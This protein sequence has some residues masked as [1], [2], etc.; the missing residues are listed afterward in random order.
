[1]SDSTQIQQFLCPKCNAEV[2]E[3]W[4]ACPACGLRLKP[5][6][7]LLPRSLAWAGVLAAYVSAVILIARYD[8]DVAHA[9]MLLVGLP[10]CYIFG[11][12]VLFRV[13]GKPLTW[14]E[15]GATSAR[16]FVVG[17][18]VTVVLPVVIGMAMVVLLF[19]VCVGAM[20]I[21]KF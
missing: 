5:G 13:R 14:K 20:A 12:A 1:M 2:R 21:G 18:G 6:G 7:D 3:E 9:F 4:V 8:H 17:L 11:K 15:L 10:L 19:A 16:T